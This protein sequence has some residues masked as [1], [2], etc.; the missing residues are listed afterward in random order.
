MSA[1][2]PA[3]ETSFAIGSLVGAQVIFPLADGN[4]IVV[5]L[6]VE[7]D[8]MTGSWTHQEGDTGALSFERK[9]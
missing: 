6:K 5:A 2:R 9:K 4:L 1:W 8:K 7:G 3:S